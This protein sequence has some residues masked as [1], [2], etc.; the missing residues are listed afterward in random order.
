MDSLH[1]ALCTTLQDRFGWPA[2]AAAE[3]GRYA[4][5]MSYEKD[6]TVFHAGEVSDLLYVLMNGEVRLYYGTV[7]GDRLLVSI[8]RSGQLF[9]ATDL[10]TSDAAS[11]Q[12][13]QLFTAQTL[14]RSKVAV[15]AR[16]RV[17]R[18]LEDLPG[19]DLVRIIQRVDSSWAGLC[20]RLLTFMTQDVRSRLAYSIGEIAKDFGIPDARGKLISLRLS[21]ED[22]AEM[23]GASRPMVSKHLK[24]MAKSGIFAKQN[25]RYVILREE[26]L[27]SIAASGRSDV[28]ENKERHSVHRLIP[29]VFRQEPE[30]PGA[31]VRIRATA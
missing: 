23:I 22:F 15:I 6:A 3:V 14:S 2:E 10:Q 18:L 26:A 13:E 20:C 5:I 24:D 31:R 7:A 30:R 29:K 9:G 25:G 19:A 11:K 16:A 12:Q 1:H 27:A 21:H 8:I 17:A 4:H 28:A